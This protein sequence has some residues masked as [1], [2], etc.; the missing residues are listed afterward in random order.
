MCW[1]CVDFY[2]YSTILPLLAVDKRIS[3]PLNE[4]Q[5]FNCLHRNVTN[6]WVRKYNGLYWNYMQFSMTYLSVTALAVHINAVT[7]WT[8][9]YYSNISHRAVMFPQIMGWHSVPANEEAKRAITRPIWWNEDGSHR[10]LD[11]NDAA[12]AADCNAINHYSMTTALA[13]FTAVSLLSYSEWVLTIPKKHVAE[14]QW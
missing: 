9:Q 5:A 8:S 3:W 11:N 4:Q 2:K 1:F 6:C 13:G 12:S 14:T 7:T 10:M